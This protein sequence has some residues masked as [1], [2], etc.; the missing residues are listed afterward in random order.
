MPY[1]FHENGQVF[2]GG[3]EV[4]PERYQQHAISHRNMAMHAYHNNMHLPVLV[5]GAGVSIHYN[6]VNGI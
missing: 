1:H 3:I 4:I 6:V 2:V 5:L